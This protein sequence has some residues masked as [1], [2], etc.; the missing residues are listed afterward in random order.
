MADG[1]GRAFR[2]DGARCGGGGGPPISPGQRAP[3][4]YGRAI[5]HG[6]CYDTNVSLWCCVRPLALTVLCGSSRG[7]GQRSEVGSGVTFDPGRLLREEPVTAVQG[8]ILCPT[9]A[10]T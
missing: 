6:R 8:F 3:P 7:R 5:K 2:G 4:V 1:A 9:S 10:G